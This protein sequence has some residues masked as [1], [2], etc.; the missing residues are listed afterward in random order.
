MC[1]IIIQMFTVTAG[2]GGAGWWF[3]FSWR[4]NNLHYYTVIV[5]LIIY[6]QPDTENRN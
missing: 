2:E 4:I 3:T 6:Y 5:Q 1:I